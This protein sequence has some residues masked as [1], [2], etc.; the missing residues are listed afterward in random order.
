MK[1]IPATSASAVRKRILKLIDC[2]DQ[3]SWASAWVSESDVLDV[4]LASDKVSY[5][6]IGTHQ[7]FTAP[8]ALDQ[9][10]AYN[11][12][13]IRVMHPN[14]GKLFH[15]K[16][17]AFDLG[18]R[19]EV[20][21]GSA[22]LTTGGLNFNVEC[23]VFLNAEKSSPALTE[24]WNHVAT[25]WG[26]AEVLDAGF[27]ASYKANHRRVRDAKEEL[28]DFVPIKKP[29]KSGRSANDIAPQD[30]K[31][32]TFVKLVKAD[33]THGLDVRL[34]VLSQAR[35]LF[36]KGHAFS[37]LEEIDQ[38][39][40]AG[41]IK[42]SGMLGVNW[43][44]FGQ[45]SAYGSYSPILQKHSKLFS[46]ALDHIPLQG[47]IKRRHYDAY[48]AAF[49][50]IPGASETWTGMG[51]RLLNMKRPDYFV[52]ID[53]ANRTGLCG[54]F[55][56]APTTTNLDNYWER[57]IAPMMQ[58]PWWQAGMPEDD[59]EQGIWLGRAAMLDAIYYDPTER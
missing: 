15:P 41:L 27:V 23:G 50:K 18:D 26:G 11:S 39:C 19:F 1:V 49:K 47:S 48:L 25:L 43:G 20:F 17:Y 58:T 13:A 21:L 52:C 31:W 9:C 12:P 32:K 44:F 56:S 30:M 4:A 36:S 53:N 2:C 10:L 55:G 28:D 45:M 34:E 51:T 46:R 57:I 3:F 33:K 22:N 16:V 8:E 5:F 35:Q 6:V 7:Y 59:V 24:F 37:D 54:Y 14:K 29:R 42:P 40:L 38:K